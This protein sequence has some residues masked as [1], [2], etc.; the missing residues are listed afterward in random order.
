MLNKFIAGFLGY[1]YMRYIKSTNPDNFLCVNQLCAVERVDVVL[2]I[3]SYNLVCFTTEI[4]AKAKV[5]SYN[6]LWAPDWIKE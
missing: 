5:D 1:S 4:P 3:K 2:W 6:R